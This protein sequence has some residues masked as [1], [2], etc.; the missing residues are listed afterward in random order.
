M[1]AFSL[2][3]A[4]WASSG[5]ALPALL[6]ASGPSVQTMIVGSGGAILSGSRTVTASPT[7]V[8]VSGRG[9]AVAA[10]TPLSALAALRRVGG[11]VFALRDYG[12][13]GSSAVNSAQL[14]V[15]SLGGERNRGQSGWEYKVDHLA[16]STGAADPSGVR[17]DGRRIRPGAHVLWFWCNASGGGCQ[18][19][20]DVRPS[21]VSVSRG[22]RFGVTI[23]AYDNEGHGAP[24]VGAVATLGSD[25]ASAGP[26]GQAMLIAPTSP[27]R[28][29]LSAGR[30]GLVPSFPETIVVR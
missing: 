7:T 25:F 29:S 11:P 21:A 20:L 18:R 24:A 1:T 2:A 17:G 23:S 9:C 12:R 22:Q 3:P 26:H 8:R 19:T 5:N 27:G 4:L 14:F 15:Y 10:G 13:C 16:G 30:P 6:A 28:Y